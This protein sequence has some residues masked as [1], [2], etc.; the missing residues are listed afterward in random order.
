[1]YPYSNSA[2][3]VLNALRLRLKMLGGEEICGFDVKS[4]DKNGERFLV[5]S[6]DGMIECR[7]VIIAAGGYAAP[8]IGTDGSIMR[9]LRE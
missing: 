3:T 8:S 4:V 2:A 6:D 5:R 9:M 7:R 1:M